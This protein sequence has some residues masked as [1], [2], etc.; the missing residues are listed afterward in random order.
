MQRF[1]TPACSCQLYCEAFDE[2]WRAR[3]RPSARSGPSTLFL[4]NNAEGEGNMDPKRYFM[5]ERECFHREH[6]VFVSK[7]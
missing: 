6:T 7:K 5:S 4:A 3:D 2:S 1:G